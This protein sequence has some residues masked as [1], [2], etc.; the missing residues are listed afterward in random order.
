MG[1]QTGRTIDPVTFRELITKQLWSL[2]E[3]ATRAHV[4]KRTVKYAAAGHTAANGE[5][6][7]YRLEIVQKMANTLGVDPDKFSTPTRPPHRDTHA[8]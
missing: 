2:E 5:P 6:R 3:F 1:R 8:A 7:A 4:G